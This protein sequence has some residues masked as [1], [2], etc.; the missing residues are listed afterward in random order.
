[1]S[2]PEDK[3]HQGRLEVLVKALEVANYTNNIWRIKRNSQQ[4]L[5]KFLAMI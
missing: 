3:R 1:M 5:M 4:S 2:V